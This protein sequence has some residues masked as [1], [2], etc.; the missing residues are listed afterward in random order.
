VGARSVPGR[1]GI[2]PHSALLKNDGRGH[3]ID[4]TDDAAPGLSHIGMVTDATWRDV[5]GDGRPDLVVVG[6]WMPITIYRN[7]GGGRLA[8]MNVPGLEKSDGWWNRIVAGDFT[9]DGRVDFIV[10]NLGLNTRLQGIGDAPV[11]MYVKDFA[12][13]GFVQQII[14]YYNHGKQYPLALR[15]DLI[16]YL[17]YLRSRYPNYKDY[18]KQ[19]VGD[20]FPPK[21][22]NDAVVKNAYTF[23][24]TL[25]KNNGDGS[26]TMVPLALET[27]ISP[28]YGIYESDVDGDGKT[29]LLLAGN[30]DGVKPEIGKMSAGYGLYLRG[31][32]KG[33]FTPVSEVASGFLVPGQ[34]RDIQRVRTRRGI[35]YVVARNNDAP[36]IFRANGTSHR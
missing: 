18:A 9:G 34:A 15:G 11:T 4:V 31:D 23:A 29:D 10:G 28:V 1:Y 7:L 14:S 17:S 26:F 3:F 5:D 16:R 32:G 30:F 19:T 2:D 13:N 6:E 25:V 8:K 33:H 22:L 35:L 24:T 12:N 20:I 36:L 21:E 27:Q